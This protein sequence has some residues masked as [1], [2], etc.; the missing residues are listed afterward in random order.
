MELNQLATVERHEAGAEFQLL[1]PA[2]GEKEDAIFKVKGTD[3]KA[4]RKAQKEQRR[5]FEGQDDVDFFDHEYIWP[6]VASVIMDW[7]KLVKDGKPFKYSEENASWLCE[8]SPV[9][10]S[11]IFAFIVDRDNFTE[12]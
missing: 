11:Q 2:T 10:V 7:D 9:V 6:I 1:N 3:S 5:Q 4:W 12:D 8:N